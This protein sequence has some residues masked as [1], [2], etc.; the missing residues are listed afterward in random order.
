M[1]INV[2]TFNIRCD[3]PIDGKNVFSKRRRL[4]KKMIKR[5]A[6]DVIGFQEVQPHIFGWLTKTFPEYAFLGVGRNADFSGEAVPVAYRKDKFTALSF[7]QFWLSDTPE[8]PGSRYTK[9]QSACP[10]VCVIATLAVTEN[11]KTFCFANTHLDHKG[12]CAKEDGAKLIAS[13]LSKCS[14]PFILTGDFNAKPDEQPIRVILENK[15]IKDATAS[16]GQSFAT[17]H[18]YGKI[19]NNFKIDYIFTNDNAKVSELKVHTDE[20]RGVFLSDHYPV[21]VNISF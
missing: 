6:P 9:D 20:K 15:S 14:L 21:S 12:E 7:R 3:V 4:I 17:Y 5:E 18:E 19:N 13:E 16:L 2:M 8:V 11:G 10:R 1:K